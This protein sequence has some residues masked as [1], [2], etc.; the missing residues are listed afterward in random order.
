MWRQIP[1]VVHLSALSPLVPVA[2]LAAR[3]LRAPAHRWILA[4]CLL[5]VFG[6]AAGLFT[7]LR[8][9]N[10][11][12]ISYLV[13]PLMGAAML[14]ALAWWQPTHAE[15]A[16]VRVSAGLLLAASLLLAVVVEDRA[17][18]SNYAIPLASLL[19]LAGAVWTLVRRAWS[20]ERGDL[21]R[22]DWFWVA[23]GF[24]VYGMVTAAYFPLA[25][26]LTPGDRSF[27]I[28]VLQLKSALVI[29]AFGLVGW[30]VACQTSG[31]R[32]GR[33]SSSSS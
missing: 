32:S 17:N 16:G 20:G 31:G 24:A 8:G 19:V 2:V 12:W 22:Q 1:L 27:V 9:M 5:S 3:G 30:G 11:Q 15:R 28:A 33:S 10:N 23:A 25:A 4:A 29:L 7:A 18:F 13:T 26:L 6:D 21:L 14:G